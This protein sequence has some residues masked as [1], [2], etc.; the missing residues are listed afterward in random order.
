[1][2]IEERDGCFSPTMEDREKGSRQDKHREGG[3]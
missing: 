3:K 1:M 2:T